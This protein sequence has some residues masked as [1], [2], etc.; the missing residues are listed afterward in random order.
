M[1]EVSILEVGLKN[2]R[3]IINDETFVFH[4]EDIES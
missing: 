4:I 3:R 2:G 1:S